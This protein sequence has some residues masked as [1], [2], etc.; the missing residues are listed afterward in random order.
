M[1][2]FVACFLLSFQSY[3]EIPRE[4]RINVTPQHLHPGEDPSARNILI[5]Q[6]SPKI[7]QL[8]CAA[9]RNTNIAVVTFGNIP[10]FWESKLGIISIKNNVR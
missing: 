6:H 7:L 1:E 8:P 3:Q 2:V 4:K 9:G 5:Y 10:V